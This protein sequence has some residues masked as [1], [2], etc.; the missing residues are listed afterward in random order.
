VKSSARPR[1]WLN[2]TTGIVLHR[3]LSLAAKYQAAIAANLSG[4]DPGTRRLEQVLPFTQATIRA[5]WRQLEAEGLARIELRASRRSKIDV[6]GLAAPGRHGRQRWATISSDL[7]VAALNA[8]SGRNA[9]YAPLLIQ[10]LLREQQKRGAAHISPAVIAADTAL[11]PKLVLSLLDAL[12]H[13]RVIERHREHPL[14]SDELRVYTVALGEPMH[15]IDTTTIIPE[16]T[17][18]IECAE[19]AGHE[20]TL[21]GAQI[22]HNRLALRLAELTEGTPESTISATIEETVTGNLTGA[23]L[24][25]EDLLDALRATPTGTSS[26]TDPPIGA[27]PRTASSDTSTALEL[28]L[29]HYGL[30]A[31]IEEGRTDEPLDQ[32]DAREQVK[33]KDREERDAV[34]LL[35]RAAAAIEDALGYVYVPQPLQDD[36]RRVLW[37]FEHAHN[38]DEPLSRAQRE[39]LDSFLAKQVQRLAELPNDE[40]KKF[41]IVRSAVQ[42]AIGHDELIYAVKASQHNEPIAPE[43]LALLGVSLAIDD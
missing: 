8:G 30:T 34:A 12:E 19:T 27:T 29:A 38:A 15:P 17:Q 36:L 28:D 18:L 11:R 26:D 21:I 23:T 37:V 1:Y 39:T 32:A 25:A 5:G 10:R 6:T 3:G 9:A 2:L 13:T 20:L 40:P 22:D 31:V 42:R 41:P 24:L 35:P 14:D 43:I 4:R 7:F 33:S 16:Q